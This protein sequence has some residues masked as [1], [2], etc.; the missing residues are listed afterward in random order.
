MIAGRPLGHD[1]T[2]PHLAWWWLA[3][4]LLDI[5]RLECYL[6]SMRCTG[7][8]LSLELSSHVQATPLSSDGAQH[9]TGRQAS[10]PAAPGSTIWGTLPNMMQPSQPQ[11]VNTAQRP[12]IS[13]QAG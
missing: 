12:S 8:E 11:T 3:L 13:T 7:W 10:Q 2:C 4:A 1:S 6:H 9:W 5:D